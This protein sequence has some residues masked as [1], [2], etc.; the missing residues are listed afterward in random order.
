MEVRMRYLES[1]FQDPAYNLALEQVVFDRLPRTDSYFML[2][3]NQNAIIVGRHQNTAQE[4]DAAFVRDR[5]IK[6]VRRL[7]G[8]GAVYHDLGNLNFTY[9]TDSAPD[10]ALDMGF[11]CRPV[12]RALERLG[13]Q[14]QLNG[15]NDITVDGQKF[16]GN[17]QYVKEGRVMHHGTI[18]FDSDLSV[19]SQALTVRADKLASHAVGSVRS[20]VTNLRPY[21]PDDLTLEAFR[22]EF[23]NA[24]F[25]AAP[26]QP[27]HWTEE[28]LQAA[29]L[30]YDQRYNT[31]DWNYGA[32]P[33]GS[34]HKSR[35]IEDCGTIEVF[36]S[37]D[38]GHITELDFRGDWFGDED[39]EPL[40]QTLIGL[41]LDLT[42]LEQTLLQIPVDRWFKGLSP[43]QLA[44]LI[45]E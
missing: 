36:L 38:K 32:S 35:R 27:Y 1:P 21:L 5:D 26:P 31:W 40:L 19:V 14:A 15:R 45:A 30:L 34:L 28:D 17:A 11:F 43:R 6:V 4:I 39:L 22:V 20:R 23:L 42:A 10:S 33:K 16:S 7:S 29:Q 3:Q 41:P 18:L 24:L 13:V 12:A 9:V 37:L 44:Q 8:G 25:D 2:W